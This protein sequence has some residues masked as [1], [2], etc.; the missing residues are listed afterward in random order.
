MELLRWE[1]TSKVTNCL[2]IML[3]LNHVPGCHIQTFFE[4]F[5]MHNLSR[6]SQ[7][8]PMPLVNLCLIQ[9]VPQ[10]KLFPF[11]R[12]AETYS[13]VG[14][15]HPQKLYLASILPHMR[16]NMVG[17]MAKS[18]KVYWISSQLENALAIFCRVKTVISIKQIVGE[19]KQ[20]NT[21]TK[22]VWKQNKQKTH[23]D[24]PNVILDF[25]QW[26]LL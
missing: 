10:L 2:P 5:I 21:L 4:H 24:A 3:S 12:K 18:R 25:L 8:L 16:S 7:D 9:S 22:P 19:N 1:K 15:S 14:W 26:L 6:C 20:K 13:M 17:L 23:K 11:Q